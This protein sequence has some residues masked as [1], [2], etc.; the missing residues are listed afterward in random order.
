MT[1]LSKRGESTK[2]NANKV[3]YKASYEAPLTRKTRLYQKLDAP[4]IKL[5]TMGHTLMNLVNTI[6]FE[7]YVDP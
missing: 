6:L 7:K 1:L 3:S 5:Q 4:E 2:T